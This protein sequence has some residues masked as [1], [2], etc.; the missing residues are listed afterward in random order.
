MFKQIFDFSSQRNWKQAILLYFSYVILM[1]IFGVLLIGLFFTV[2]KFL[3]INLQDE[4]LII[5]YL[6]IARSIIWKINNIIYFC[7]CIGIPIMFIIKKKLRDFK[8]LFLLIIAI[9][10]YY[11]D[12][13]IIN[14]IPAAILSMFPNKNIS[15]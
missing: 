1:L 7:F 8:S 4:N 11:I 6:V 5:H 12:L 13:Q 10:F 2:K 15:E 9:V 3:L 14:I